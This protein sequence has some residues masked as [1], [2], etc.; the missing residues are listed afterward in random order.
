[1]CN[2]NIASKCPGAQDNGNGCLMESLA[3]AYGSGME[4]VL[5]KKISGS[6]VPLK[7]SFLNG[8]PRH[9]A[10]SLSNLV[11]DANG[12]RLIKG[13]SE[14]AERRYMKNP[15]RLAL[16][17]LSDLIESDKDEKKFAK[18]EQLCFR[19]GSGS[20]SCISNSSKGAADEPKVSDLGL[21]TAANSNNPHG[22]CCL[23]SLVLITLG[24]HLPIHSSVQFTEHGFTYGILD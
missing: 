4:Q 22:D 2:S 21:I 13:Y 23:N 14:F 16:K 1:M 10:L 18:F 3:F 7:K 17:G 24:S 5:L 15:T 11:E 6:R 20:H 8:S 9:L 12:M 19:C